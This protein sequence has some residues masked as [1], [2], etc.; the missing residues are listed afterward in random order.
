MGEL[1]ATTGERR[2]LGSISYSPQEVLN[3][4]K[5]VSN[6]SRNRRGFSPAR[7]VPT[8]CLVRALIATATRKSFKLVHSPMTSHN[9]STVSLLWWLGICNQR[10]W[11]PVT[12]LDSWP[13]LVVQV[14]QLWLGIVE[15]RC[16]EVSVQESPWLVPATERPTSTC[17]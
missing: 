5:I 12:N 14:I 6:I 16:Q 4:W 17:S 13:D 15:L 9:G 8:Y 11:Q 10:L 3:L 2:L 7:S 1:P